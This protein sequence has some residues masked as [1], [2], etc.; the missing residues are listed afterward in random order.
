[1]VQNQAVCWKTL[2]F[3]SLLLLNTWF[4][5]SLLDQFAFVM[6]N[7]HG[8]IEAQICPTFL[9][10]PTALNTICMRSNVKTLFD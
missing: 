7:T 1:M 3:V 5:I 4:S 8:K 10:V 9:C 2:L 6:L